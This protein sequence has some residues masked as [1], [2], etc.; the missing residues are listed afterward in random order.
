MSSHR[1]GPDQ[2]GPHTDGTQQDADGAPAGQIARA[3]AVLEAVAERGSNSARTIAESTRIPLPTVY[4]ITQELVR[5]G[6]LVHLK[7]EKRFALGYHLH[8]LAV[9]LHEDLGI[10]RTVRQEVQAMFRDLGMASYLAVHRGA[11]FVVVHVADS[12]EHPRLTPMGFGFHETPH[13]TAFGKVGLSSLE[14]DERDSYLSAAPLAANT[15]HTITDPDVLRGHLDEIAARGVAWE[16]EEFQLGTACLAAAIR[17]DDGMLLGTVA[18]SAPIDAYQGR[19]SHVEH[20]VRAC[21]SRAGRAYR[22]GSHHC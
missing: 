17:A 1:G 8:R 3:I 5:A 4:R 2:D 11:D 6:Y 18:V 15:E 10:P 9:G 16:H 14:L 7:D 19:A 21:A 20:R 12:A 22:L 13:A